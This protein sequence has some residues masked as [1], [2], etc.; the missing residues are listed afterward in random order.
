M[1]I[2]TLAEGLAACRSARVTLLDIAENGECDPE[3]AAALELARERVGLAALALDAA[4]C[5]IE[6]LERRLQAAQTDLAA[7]NTRLMD[8]GIMGGGALADR[9]GELARQAAPVVEPVADA[10]M[11]D[12]PRR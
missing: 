2:P 9:V 6:E 8:A 3:T 12:D 10:D 7:V 11:L 4:D 5:R 1:P